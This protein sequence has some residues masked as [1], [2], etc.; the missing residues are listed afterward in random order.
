LEYADIIYDNSTKDLHNKLEHIQR[1]A[2]LICTGAYR[3]TENRSLMRELNWE[4]LALRRKNHKLIHYYKIINGHTPDY[5]KREIPD[6][7]STLSNY[8]LRNRT[9]LRE[10][11]TRLSSRYNSFFPSTT[12]LWNTLPITT[13]N[14]PTTNAFKHKISKKQKTPL[15]HSLCSGRKGNLI[16]RLRLGLSALNA[17]RFKYNCIHSPNCNYCNTEIESTKHFFFDCPAFII[18]RTT[19]LNRINDELEL[20]TTNKNQLMHHFLHGTL[21]I[22]KNITLKQIILDYMAATKRFQKNP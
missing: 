18:A 11:K 6:A 21:D 8:R 2:G 1:R 3:H 7:I 22:Q 13:K 17:H 20:D 5:L 10:H 19:L 12:R 9:Q 14:L 15:Y 4:S 16:T